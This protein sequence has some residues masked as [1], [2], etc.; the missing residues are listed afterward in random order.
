M[1]NHTTELI[2]RFILEQHTT[3]TTSGTLT[4]GCFVLDISGFT[5]LTQALMQ[6]GDS[7]A[8]L[9]SSIINEIFDPV[10][11]VIRAYGGFVSAFAGDAC[12]AI[13]PEADADAVYAAA[14][15]A[16]NEVLGRPLKQTPHG[17]FPIDAK[18]GVGSGTI[19]WG[20][21]RGATLNTYYVDGAALTEAA[22]AQTRC[23][24]GKIMI[25]PGAAKHLTNA[26]GDDDGFVLASE[27]ARAAS[28]AVG[29]ASQPRGTQIEPEKME[30]VLGVYVPTG[31]LPLDIPGEFRS[32]YSVFFSLQ[33][34]RDHEEIQ[35]T[36]GQI[37]DLTT[38]Y[39]GYFNLLDYGDKGYV[40]L[41]LFGAPSSHGDDLTRA[42]QLSLAVLSALGDRVRIGLAAGLAFAG[43]VG[44]RDR[45]TYTALGA[46]VNLSARLALDAQ[47]CSVVVAGEVVDRLGDRVGLTELYRRRFKGFSNEL[48][49]YILSSGGAQPITE[50]AFVARPQL[51]E[52]IRSAVDDMLD[53]ETCAYYL[54]GEPGSGKSRLV[55]ETLRSLPRSITS[56]TLTADT[57]LRKSLNAVPGIIRSVFALAQIDLE[58]Q[59]MPQAMEA[60]ADWFVQHGVAKE[61]IAQLR[62]AESGLAAV[63]G[64][65]S[66]DSRYARLD[67]QARFELT[68]AGIGTL[69]TCL[70]VVT[71][72]IIVIDNANALDADTCS[73]CSRIVAGDET[74][75]F[76]MLFVGRG[77]TTPTVF[78]VEEHVE[79]ERC[80]AV[81]GL[82]R[83]EIDKVVAGVIQGPPDPSL[84]DGIM[85]RV[86]NNAL[87]VGELAR[88]LRRRGLL[89]RDS[90]GYR[91][92]SDD[93]ALP[94]GINELLMARIDSLPAN[95]RTAAQ[96]AVVFGVEF[97][98]ELLA[99]L[100]AAGDDFTQTLQ[101]GETAGLWQRTGTGSYRFGQ[102]I[103]RQ[104]L[105][106]MQL[107]TTL[108]RMHE[109]AAAIVARLRSDDPSIAA[110][111]A[112]HYTR[113]GMRTEA[114]GA[115][116]KAANYALANF[117]NEKALEFLR[118]LRDYSDS[119]PVNITSYRD[120]AGVYE[121]TGKWQD[122]IDALTYA[123]GMSIVHGDGNQ[124]AALL[125]N[126]G[127]L[128]RKQSDLT[129][130][131]RLLQQ[132]HNLATSRDDRA[133]SA[134]SLIY[135]GQSYTSRG[136]YE[137]A[138]TYLSKAH[139]TSVAIGDKKL[140]GLSL[141]YEGVIFRVQNRPANAESNFTESYSI[142]TSLGDNRLATYPLYDLGVLKLNAGRL[143][144]AQERFEQ[145]LHTYR[146]IGY[147]SGASAATL[148]LGVLR[149][150]RGDFD[151]AITYY[152]ASRAMA[153]RV[154][155]GLAI[156]YALFSIGATYYKMG[157]LRKSPLYLKRS[158]DLIK[159][160]GVRGYYGYPLSYLVSVL[161]KSGD[162][163]RAVRIA[164]MHTRLVSEIGTDPEN[165]RA[166]MSLGETLERGTRLNAESN[167]ML[168]TIAQHYRLNDLTPQAF[169]R[170]A[171]EIS[172]PTIYVDTL[173]PSHLRLALCERSAGSE[174]PF[175]RH[176]A[177]AFTTALEAH[178]DR[179]VRGSITKYGPILR[180]LG[181]L[182]NVPAELR[183][184]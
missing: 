142:F 124:R 39:G 27:P 93:V 1:N 165:G 118:D 67:P 144:E 126:L 162:G 21:V 42:T 104:T 3:H 123:V 88:Y 182:D 43:Y 138:H 107:S 125:M 5:P 22:A 105:A 29:S 31:D 26:E 164:H 13:F 169:Y 154:N 152:Q 59:S 18:V 180:E 28:G 66:E 155:E 122:A 171:I 55:R 48:P 51:Q 156:G 8:E 91:V 89:E 52:Q 117:K 2:P 69:V 109:R 159:G 178:W 87:Y 11:T 177:N 58:T 14:V 53:T 121:L 85:H 151:A 111:L 150:R 33:H 19:H 99:E 160:L 116:R 96:S 6:H 145:A 40:A 73:V 163:N 158:F 183:E 64:V 184:R 72:T 81:G 134:E 94:T 50:D 45:A 20:I 86:G 170:K 61:R 36:A 25:G 76:G 101:A 23:P 79:P 62:E 44:N 37:L 57:I 119:P 54:V 49:V 24:K 17:D 132:A 168:K 139:D 147:L 181:L 75:N 95:V 30:A 9:L 41:V 92:V 135:L 71:P 112:Y 7:G 166:V 113:A 47:F 149:D 12:T 98:P 80:I 103:V 140:E 143:D 120:T 161:A 65:V 108:K 70:S 10:V 137:T 16:R 114:A 63:L 176:L 102:D 56:L 174:E 82:A 153:E 35:H 167:A 4:G 175:R 157:D 38:D 148:N 128:Y 173:I 84:I 172:A 83:E 68:A 131:I 115:L 130:A 32:V 136:E 74:K 141:Y 146:Q 34:P 129:T 60:L 106:D 133:V 97:D 110:N 90:A 46:P 127:E 179:F 15:R 77:D 100:I 78:G